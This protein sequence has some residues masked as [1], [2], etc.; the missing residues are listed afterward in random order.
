MT[1]LR[2]HP[3]VTIASH[4][5]E[6]GIEVNIREIPELVPFSVRSHADALISLLL[7]FCSLSREH[8][9]EFAFHFPVKAD[10]IAL[11]LQNGFAYVILSHEP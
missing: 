9:D 3:P 7:S 2:S 11:K 4:S 1:P 5:S 8:T 10:K 6:G